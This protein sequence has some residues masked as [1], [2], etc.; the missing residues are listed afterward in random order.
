MQ[1]MSGLEL[2]DYVRS[3]HLLKQLPVIFV[4]AKPEKDIQHLLHG[5]EKNF[6]LGK[7]FSFSDLKKSVKLALT[8]EW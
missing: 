5:E 7:P 1:N 4:T 8:V 2:L 6:Y 3:N